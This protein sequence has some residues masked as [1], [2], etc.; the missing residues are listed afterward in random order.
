VIDADH[1][2]VGGRER[3]ATIK[4]EAGLHPVRLYYRGPAGQ[5]TPMLNVQWS[6][7]SHTERRPI[8]SS[9]FAR[10]TR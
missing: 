2:Y 9:A 3:T 8:P 5:S 7:P 10:E 4:L 6:G 1:G